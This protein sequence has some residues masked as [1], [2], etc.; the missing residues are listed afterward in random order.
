MF[1]SAFRPKGSMEEQE[2]SVRKIGGVGGVGW[3]RNGAS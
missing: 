3:N 2:D 1:Q